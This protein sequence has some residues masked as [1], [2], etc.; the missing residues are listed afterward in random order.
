MKIVVLAHNLHT[1]GGLSVGKDIVATLPRVAPMHQYLMIV[2]QGKAYPDFSGNEDVKILECPVSLKKR[3]FWERKHL[4]QALE[5]FAPD[6][7]WAIGNIPLKNPIASQ[8]LLMHNPHLLNYHPTWLWQSTRNPFLYLYAWCRYCFRTKLL[9]YWI[10]RVVN[11]L[12]HVYCQTGTICKRFA[13][14]YHCDLSKT[15][16]FRTPFSPGLKRLASDAP[17]DPT[18]IPQSI[19]EKYGSRFKLFYPS[20]PFAHKNME[21]I[22]WMYH[23]HRDVLASTACILPISS[24]G[25]RQEQR[26]VRMI[27][28]CKVEDFFWL[29]G[30]I[31]QELMSH[32][33]HFTDVVFFPSLLETLGLGHLEGM[34]CHRPVIA[35]D[36]DFA[37][38]VCGDAAYY[39]DPYSTGSMKDG[40]LALQQST[41]LCKSLTERGKAHFQRWLGTWDDAIKDVLDQEKIEHL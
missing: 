28:Q 8:S 9:S 30:H 38:D 32:Y 15:H 31:P 29:A 12:D 19:Q 37:H 4:N 22:V 24:E 3:F 23:Q 5:S 10:R 39:V 41:E 18:V 1:G 21:K 14:Y 34:Y 25:S 33:Y 7:I 36:L 40:I 6:W 2:P 16:I 27:K 20:L 26:I 35:S 11:D 13:D 17:V